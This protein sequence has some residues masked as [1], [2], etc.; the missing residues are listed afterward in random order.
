M[1]AI[2]GIGNPMLVDA[3]PLNQPWTARREPEAG[4]AATVAAPQ[5]SPS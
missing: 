3:D 1:T 4:P 2:P 5:S